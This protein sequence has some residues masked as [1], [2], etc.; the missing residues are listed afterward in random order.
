MDDN[1]LL[2]NQEAYDAVAEEYEARVENLR[3]VT[4]TCVEFLKP[5]IPFGEK[6]L[7]VGCGVGLMVSLLYHEGYV[8]E[9]IELSSNMVKFSQARNPSCPIY[10]DDFLGHSFPCA[11]RGITALAFIHLFPK[12]DALCVLQKMHDLLLPGG[13]LYIG[14][15]K[16]EIS[17]EGWE[18]KCDY[19]KKARRFR[20]HWTEDEFRSILAEAGFVVLH[21]NIIS[22]PFGKV[23]MDMVARKVEDIFEVMSKK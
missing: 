15:T 5:H 4:K 10:E 13:I 17:S 14:T 11:Y 1:Y 23:W 20:K 6:V 7:D 2:A 9:G 22:D 21:C 18:E 8:A 12:N 16:S 19:Q 3:G